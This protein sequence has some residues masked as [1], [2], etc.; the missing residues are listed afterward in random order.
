VVSRN[1]N[2]ARRRGGFTLLELLLALALTA[3]MVPILF[4]ALHAA[5][6]ARSTSERALA[7]S[8]T[9][10]MAFDMLRADF[11]SMPPITPSATVTSTSLVATA[12]GSF[13]SYFEGTHGSDD[14]GHQGDVV[15]FFVLSEGQLRPPMT[16]GSGINLTANSKLGGT[17]GGYGNSGTWFPSSETKLVEIT[18][19]VPQG[20]TDHCLVRKVWHNLPSLNPNQNPSPDP[21]EEEVIVRGVDAFSVRYYDGSDWQDT[22]DST[23][24]DNQTPAAV[25]ITLKIEAR[26]GELRNTEPRQYV[27]VIQIPCSNVVN[28][29]TLS[30]T[31][32]GL[33]Q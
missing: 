12:P 16:S 14:R 19:D 17:S 1:N 33:T 32:T 3:A 7:P 6:I 23:T 24:V 26:P 21:D 5:A 30:G 27:Q 13:A 2:F 8:R 9:A 31:S 28:D 22:W 18:I 4:E 10:Q 11:Q 15:D 20:S 25:E 29:T